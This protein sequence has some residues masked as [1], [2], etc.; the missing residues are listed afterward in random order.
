[1]TTSLNSRRGRLERQT[2]VRLNV[3]NA[4]E[5]LD[6][7]ELEGF[8]LDESVAM[9][10]QSDLL[11]ELFHFAD[12]LTALLDGHIV[13]SDTEGALATIQT[14]LRRA[15]HTTA[16][17]QHYQAL[18]ETATCLRLALLAPD[19]IPDPRFYEAVDE[20][21]AE[22]DHLVDETDFVPPHLW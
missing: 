13:A 17:P 18:V 19:L 7:L 20:L 11:A 6:L 12:T 3:E 15:D 10:G 8:D 21:L 16:P 1:M 5:E 4:E 22:Y 2:L 9:T 14:V